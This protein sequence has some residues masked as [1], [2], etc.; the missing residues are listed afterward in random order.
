MTVLD[1]LVIAVIAA[2]IV[3]CGAAIW[4]VDRRRR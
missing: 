4:V 2:L 3:I 1:W